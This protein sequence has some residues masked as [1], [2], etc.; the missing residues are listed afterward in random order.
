MYHFD[1]YYKRLE[2][3]KEFSEKKMTCKKVNIL[4]NILSICNTI[5][6]ALP[7][8]DITIQYGESE[9]LL[10]E[11]DD[12]KEVK[13]II[14]TKDYPS[15]CI[16]FFADNDRIYYVALRKIK[17]CNMFLAATY[18]KCQG[19][20]GLKK[21]IEHYLDWGELF[22]NLY[23]DR[24]SG[25][26]YEDVEQIKIFNP[27]YTIKQ[28]HRLRHNLDCDEYSFFE[29]NKEQSFCCVQMIGMSKGWKNEFMVISTSNEI[30]NKN[31]KENTLKGYFYVFKTNHVGTY[32]EKTTA[33][34]CN[35]VI[36]LTDYLNEYP[37]CE[38]IGLSYWP[39]KLF[40]YKSR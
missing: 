14:D 12:I 17:W 24:P 23:W 29:F 8:F 40:S 36:G 30:Y 1:K 38:N 37:K 7:E 34:C 25:F 35:G 33:I 39:A 10:R 4:D 11:N 28:Y 32:K 5:D 6:M 16:D 9:S 2:S 15:F 21:L 27:Q 20:A 31:S 18:F 13:I 26:N 19:A 22:A 3:T